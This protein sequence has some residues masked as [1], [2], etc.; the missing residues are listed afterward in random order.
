MTGS[1]EGQLADF[2]QPSP[3]VVD[4]LSNVQ[5][6]RVLDI[7]C[8]N[9]RN[10]LYLAERGWQVTALDID[11]A[12]LAN[13]A[14]VA[15]S[16]K[17]SIDIQNR[18]ITKYQPAGQFEAIICLMTLHFLSADDVPK[19]ITAIQDWTTPGGLNIISAF[20]SDN[21]INTR[22]FLFAPQSLVEAYARWN[23]ERYKEGLTNWI[24][25]QGKTKPEQYMAA[26]LV[27]RRPS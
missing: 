9:G 5:P 14:A 21:P 26:R 1:E 11:Q 10:S 25:P 2:S 8:E 15:K 17:L 3:L 20:T 7:G 18:D 6:G 19:V 13:L 12:A 16:K 22:P 4:A 27:A 24:V 23:V